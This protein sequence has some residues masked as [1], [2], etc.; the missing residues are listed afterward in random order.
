M[1]NRPQDECMLTGS[2][3]CQISSRRWQPLFSSSRAYSIPLATEIASP[4]ITANINTITVP[5]AEWQ[6]PRGMQPGTSTVLSRGKPVT[7]LVITT[8]TYHA[9][10]AQG[11][12]TNDFGIERC[13]P[14]ALDPEP[15]LGAVAVR[16]AELVLAAAPD[17]DHL[18]P[19]PDAALRDE[20]ADPARSAGGDRRLPLDVDDHRLHRDQRRGDG[21]RRNGGR[22]SPHML[23]VERSGPGRSRPY[24]GPSRGD[25]LGRRREGG[26]RGG[27]RVLECGTGLAWLGWPAS[28]RYGL[29][30]TGAG[31]AKPGGDRAGAG[32]LAVRDLCR[33]DDAVSR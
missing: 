31:S 11:T 19:G 26:I 7:L 13:I 33:R 9:I 8:N 30:G 22:V 17:P 3:H 25:I 21:R 4:D 28:P 6:V 27:A 29:R 23:R 12:G 10:L 18:R 16:G 2:Q 24:Q 15:G 14:I 1:S 32:S 20:V 5:F